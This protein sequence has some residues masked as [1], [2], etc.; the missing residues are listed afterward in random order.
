MA[1]DQ[2]E[3]LTLL[4]DYYEFCT[5][6]F[7]DNSIVAEAPNNGGWPTITPT[8]MANLH[9][10]DAAIELLCHMPFVDFEPGKAFGKHVVMRNTRI[11]DYRSK[12]IQDGSATGILYT[13]LSPSCA[14]ASPCRHHASVSVTATGV[15][16]TF[17]SSTR[18]TV[19][20]I[21]GIPPVSTTSQ[22]QSSMP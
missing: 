12:E 6:A 2:V 1:F 16:A 7:W 22:R 14:K 13:M 4:K 19:T 15:M 17:S 18:L 11:Q 9:K 20:S 10:T 3:F 5:R 8:T 21:G